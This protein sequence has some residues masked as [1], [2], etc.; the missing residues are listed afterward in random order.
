[1]ISQFAL[2]NSYH[3]ISYQPYFFNDECKHLLIIKA[4]LLNF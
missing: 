3:Y 1:M 2:I 4:A